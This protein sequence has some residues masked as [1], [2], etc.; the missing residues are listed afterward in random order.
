MARILIALGGNALLQNGDARTYETQ[1]E[2]AYKAFKLLNGVLEKED[3]IIT[4][5]NGP[6]VGDI[7]ARNE[8][9]GELPPS[10]PV[11]ACGSM[12]QGLIG[13]ML[14]EAYEMVRAESGIGKIASVTLTRSLVDS[15]DSAFGNPTK[16]VGRSYEKEEA[17]AIMKEKGWNMVETDRGWRRVVPSPVPID[18]L[19]KDIIMNNLSSGFLPICTGG[20]GIPVKKE[21]N[22]YTGVD[23]VIDK[24]LASSVLAYL[25]E[26][27]EL[28]IL[29][30]VKNVYINYGKTNQEPLENVSLEVAKKYHDGGQFGKGSM[31][32]KVR[33]AILFLEH[34]GKIARIGNLNEALAVVRGESGTI[35]TRN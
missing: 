5:G 18:I 11:H 29:T 28:I 32:P 27:D 17:L 26:M 13:E 23:A 25:L 12:S 35:I 15:N 16:P 3:V 20:G 8:D 2:R 22:F 4:H 31:G 7:M 24:D 9:S 30:D 33:A 14:L 6:Q 10:M 21:G 34:G 19:E 1:K